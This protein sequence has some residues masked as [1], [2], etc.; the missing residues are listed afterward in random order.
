MSTS[1]TIRLDQRAAE[2]VGRLRRNAALEV[3][4]QAGSVWLRGND[5]DGGVEDIFRVLPGERFEILPD[6]QLLPA[7][8][9]VPHGFAPAGRWIPLAQWMSLQLAPAAFAGEVSQRLALRIE[10]GGAE[11]QANLLWTSY[12]HWANYAAAAPQVRL[13]PLAFAM[14]DDFDVL[15]RG[16]PLPPIRGR[17]LVETEGVCVE[18]GW[19]W[20]PQV[21]ARVIRDRLDLAPGDLAILH[22]DGSWDRIAG[23][24]FVRAT[25]S[26][27]RL[28]AG[29]A[30]G[31]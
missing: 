24:A 26:A 16:A 11:Q 10:R 25:R 31:R 9:R 3:C 22:A 13:D 2:V 19:T 30:D 1:W 7:G 17:R 23:D 4:E 21:A 6:G 28:S 29:V 12:S 14:N 18:A 8:R 20:R 27:V 15:I 5:S